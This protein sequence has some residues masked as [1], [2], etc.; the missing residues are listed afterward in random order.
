MH[1]NIKNLISA[2]KKPDGKSFSY[3]FFE[4]ETLSPEREDIEKFVSRCRKNKVSCIIP[5]LPS[6]DDR[7]ERIFAAAADIYSTLISYAEESGISVGMNF[8]KIFE[9]AFFAET[10]P[11]P[12]K[13]RESLRAKLLICHE[14]YCEEKEDICAEVDEDRLLAI[15]AFDED[16]VCSIDLRKYVSD[17]T[18]KYTLPAGNWILKKYELSDRDLINDFPPSLNKLDPN[19]CLKYFS[20]VLDLIGE[21]VRRHL[22]KTLSLVYTSEISFDAPN[23]RNWSL[24]FNKRFFEEYGIDP[25][26][27]YD[28]LFANIGE[29]TSH[30]RSMFMS[31]RAKMLK[32]G[33]VRALELFAKPYGADLVFS[34]SEPKLPSCP[35]I[36]GDAL[37]LQSLSACAKLDRAYM[38]GSNSLR[39]ASSAATNYSLDKVC[40]EL[41]ENYC[42]TSSD[43]LLKETLSAL[44]G[45]ADTLLTHIPRKENAMPRDFFR[46]AAKSSSLLSGSQHICDIAMLY[47]IYSMS[48]MI[49]L[50]QYRET[51]FEYPA[52]L[53]NN[54]YMTLSNI[55]SSCCG[56]DVMLLHPDTLSSSCE[57]ED[58]LI[59]LYSSDRDFCNFKM[60]FLPA[61]SVIDLQSLH[62]LK[63]F[64][65]GGGKIIS[66]G[67]LPS[68][69]FEYDA[70]CDLAPD[71]DEM[72]FIESYGTKYDLEVR[73][74]I[75]HIFGDEAINSSIIRKYF[76]NTNKRGGVAYFIP[77]SATALDGSLYSDPELISDLLENIGVPFDVYMSALPRRVMNGGLNEAYPD[78]SALGEKMCLTDG[79]VIKYIHKRRDEGEIYLFTNT[80]DKEYNGTVFLKG[81]LS[82]VFIDPVADKRRHFDCRRVRFLGEGYTAVSMT[83]PS[84]SA[85][86]AISA[87][88]RAYTDQ[89][90]KKLPEIDSIECNFLTK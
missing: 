52:P 19:A 32:D 2:Y 87:P 49:N 64:Y 73:D 70:S 14:T 90:I 18:V 22:G 21:R 34:I 43:K 65:D 57:I 50:F 40:C 67:A 15:T 33:V 4:P 47:P 11:V 13:V 75:R 20:T 53:E 36:T 58:N 41:F 45:G 80:T 72:M 78:F 10:S 38:Y 74:I 29:K 61:T 7:P 83:V 35:W 31:C 81:L 12:R 6:T 63:K 27:Y 24:D 25:A 86:F 85:I 82:P 16:A 48:S 59:K 62:K 37:S 88:P 56:H 71:E 60:I 89:D 5:V 76:K 9:N 54:D 3:L 39:L 69:A 44:S 1:K 23:R 66:T 28:G 77:P 8:Q 17:G 42:N 84:G 30:I 55:I 79:G 46:L 51:E 26:L 68:F